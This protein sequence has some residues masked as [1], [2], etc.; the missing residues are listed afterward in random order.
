MN[1]VSPYTF[2]DGALPAQRLDLLAATYQDSSRAFLQSLA[3][4]GLAPA[5]KV[6]HAVDLGCG[7]GHTT[8][9][10]DEVLRPARV[11]GID[12]SESFVER[13]R[14]SSPAHIDFVQH[15]VRV[16]PFPCGAPDLLYARFLVTHLATPDEVLAAWYAAAAVKAT[17][18][19][20][21]TSELRSTDATFCQY[22][23]LV[24]T[25]QA[26]Y[27]QALDI[28]KRLDAIATASRWRIVRSDEDAQPRPAQTMAQL[29][30]MNIATWKRD[31]RAQ[32]LFDATLVARLERELGEIATGQR[33][34]PP[35]TTVMRRLLLAR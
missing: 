3:E 9:L 30:A 29:H 26:S 1:Q 8:R 12:A 31:A 16:A 2:G 6:D 10:V 21:E 33:S 27:G 7:P 14:A 20:E 4:S 11:T 24:A 13:A 23:E 34:A 17:L 35:V 18:A 25:L 22:Y 32:T 5:H 15:D 19:I 28:G